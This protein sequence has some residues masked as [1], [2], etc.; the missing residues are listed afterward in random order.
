MHDCTATCRNARTR[1]WFENTLLLHS[2]LYAARSSTLTLHSDHCMLYCSG[3][4]F[5]F[6]AWKIGWMTGPAPLLGPV[7]KAHQVSE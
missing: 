5:S 4:T 2:R 3:K 6:T 7:I 1:V